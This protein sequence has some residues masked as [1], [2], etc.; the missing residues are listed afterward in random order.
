MS[1][2]QSGTSARSSIARS[3][4]ASPHRVFAGGA[5][6]TRDAR[7]GARGQHE[8]HSQRGQQHHRQQNDNQGDA[9]I[10]PALLHPHRGTLRFRG[11]T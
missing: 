1:A 7:L 4:A 9:A 8:R 3:A 6:V 5:E 11:E 2:D 10:L